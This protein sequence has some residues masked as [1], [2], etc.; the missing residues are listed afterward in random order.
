MPTVRQNLIMVLLMTFM[1]SCVMSVWFTWQMA[2]FTPVFFAS[3][4]QH[5]FPTYIVVLPT[6]LLVAP[7]AQSLSQIIN[8]FLESANVGQKTRSIALEAWSYNAMGHRGEGF[9]KWYEMLAPDVAVTIPLG[10]FRGENH[11]LATAR[12]IYDAISV[13]S[14][15][16]IYDGPLRITESEQTVVIEFESHGI[17]DSHP[18]R[19]RIAASYDIRNGKVAAYREYFGD[20]D[21]V[22]VSFTN[23]LARP[24]STRKKLAV[25]P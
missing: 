23:G 19:N 22:I 2:G 13:S 16:T 24:G 5:F 12:K 25:R 3:W 4:A 1:I 18:Y 15:N 21:P 17:I 7:I 6:V 10:P 8:N 14:P 11:S 9:A 20:I